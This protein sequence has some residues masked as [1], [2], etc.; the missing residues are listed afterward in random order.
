[1]WNQGNTHFCNIFTWA[2]ISQFML[3][4]VEWEMNSTLLD[5]C[6]NGQGRLQKLFYKLNMLQPNIPHWLIAYGWLIYSYSVIVLK[7]YSINY[8]GLQTFTHY[9]IIGTG[10]LSN[11]T[12]L[13]PSWYMRGPRANKAIKTVTDWPYNDHRLVQR[14]LITVYFGAA[15]NSSDL[16]WSC[17]WADASIYPILQC[18][19]SLIWVHGEMHC[20]KCGQTHQVVLLS[21]KGF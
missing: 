8:L 5:T 1:M 13:K 18:L 2:S 10:Q 11:T 19:V 6:E 16:N 14:Y 21:F 4:S 12:D 17:I 7:W 20:C 15:H 3:H 9:C